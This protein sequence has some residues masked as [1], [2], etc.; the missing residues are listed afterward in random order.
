[1]QKIR[2]FYLVRIWFAI[3]IVIAL[4]PPLYWAA[5]AY[6]ATSILRVPVPLAYFLTVSLSIAASILY[7]YWAETASGDYTS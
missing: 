3:D 7:A 5:D 1:M 6:K 2:H 4:A